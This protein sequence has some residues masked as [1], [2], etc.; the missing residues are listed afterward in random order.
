MVRVGRDFTRNGRKIYD[1]GAS[2]G[3]LSSFGEY[4]RRG[5]WVAYLPVPVN[6]AAV[7][8]WDHVVLAGPPQHFFYLYLFL[9]R[10][11]WGIE[12]IAYRVAPITRNCDGIL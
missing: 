9:G 4:G 12:K 5:L 10:K 11:I 3:V 2:E 1:G 8:C 7:N 6:L